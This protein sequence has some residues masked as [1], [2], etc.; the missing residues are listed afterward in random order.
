MQL[1]LKKAYLFITKPLTIA[2]C[3]H[4]GDLFLSIPAGVPTDR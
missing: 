2:N 4:E 3:R 1:C